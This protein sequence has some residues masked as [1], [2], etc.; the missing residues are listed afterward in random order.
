MEV[1]WLRRR[2]GRVFQKPNPQASCV[3]DFTLYLYEGQ[4][5]YLGRTA[6]LFTNPQHEQ[7]GQYITGRF[8]WQTMNP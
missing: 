3:S 5:I 8:G 6:D 2:V 1:V 4:L 7:T